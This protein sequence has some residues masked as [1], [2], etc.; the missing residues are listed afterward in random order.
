[1]ISGQGPRRSAR[2][3][4]GGTH[5]LD[6]AVRVEG[7]LARKHVELPRQ[8]L[9]SAY[10]AL[11]C[12]VHHNES[13]LQ[14]GNVASDGIGSLCGSIHLLLEPLDLA[15]VAFKRFADVLLEVV[16]G[17]EVWEEGEYILDLEKGGVLQELHSSGGAKRASA[18]TDVRALKHKAPTSSSRSFP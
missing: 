3:G 18:S 1:M 13:I 11:G 15:R 7:M 4:T 2:K 5:L 9:R 17:D 16:N 10:I 12:C 8:K 6:E 14:L